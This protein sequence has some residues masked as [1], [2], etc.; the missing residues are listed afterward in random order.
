MKRILFLLTLSTAVLYASASNRYVSPTG[1][2]GNGKS[3]EN[4]KTTIAGA[5]WDV[6]VGDTMFIAEGVYNEA[7]SVQSG[8][9]Y[10]GGYN[11]ETGERNPELYESIIDGTDL[12]SYLI[13]KYDADPT[14]PILMDGL[15]I[16]NADNSAWG[17]AAIFWRGNM[18]LSNCIVRDCKGTSNVGGIYI[19][20]ASSAVKPV[21]KNCIFENCVCTLAEYVGA[22]FNKGGIIENC[23][24]RG[25]SA[26]IAGIRNEGG[27]IVRNCLLHNNHSDYN[28]CLYN[29]SD[30]KI[31]NTTV[32]NNTGTRYAGIRSDGNVMN[33]VFW[34][35]TTSYENINYISSSSGSG[36]NVADKGSSSSC[37]IKLNLNA[38]NNAADGPNFR[39]P[40]GFIGLPKTDVEKDAMRK[41]DFSLTDASNELLDKGT[42]EGAPEKDILG[43][44]RPKGNGIDI[45]AYEY[46]PDAVVIAVTG[47]SIAPSS[48]E[49][50]EGRTGTL[51]AQVEPADANNKR[52]EWSIDNEEIATIKN[53]VVT[54]VKEGETTARVKT[55]D[56]NYTAEATVIITPKPPVKYPKEVLEAEAT[57]KI[58][59]YTVPS[60]IP[61]LVAKQEAKI[62]SASPETTPEMIASIAEKLEVMYTRIEKLQPK[63]QPYNQIATFYGDPA[64]HMGFCWFTNGGIKDGKVQ[65]LAKADATAEDFAS[66]NGVIEVAAQTTDATLHYTP[67]QSSESPKYDICTAAGLPRNTR[68]D[69]VSHKAQ[70]TTLTPGTEYSWRVGFDG[71]WSEIAQ[72]VTKDAN[73][74]AF[75]FLYMTDSHI[76][77]Y[78][79]IGQA[80]Q[81]AE[82]V[83]KNEAN[84]KDVKFC[85][86]PGDFADTG[87][88]TNS[89][90]QWEQWFE[91]S[92]RPAL[93][94]MAFVPTDG[95]HDDSPLLNYDYHFNTDWSF[96]SMAETKP[97]FY[98]ITYSFVYGDVLFLVYSL[99]DWWRAHGSSDKNMV[100]SYITTDLANW[101]KEQIAKYP[102]TKYRV[103]VSHKNIFSGAGHHEDDECPL[104]RELMLPIFKEC[105]IDLA[106]QGHDHCYEVMGPVNPDTRTVIPGS[107]TDTVRVAAEA[108]GRW[109]RSVNKTGLE[110]G[111]FTVDDGTLYFIGAT[112]GRKRYEPYNRATMEENYTTD[113][114]ILFDNKH[115]NVKNLFDLFTSKFGQPGAPSYTRFNVSNAGIEMVTY[116]TDEDGNK[117]E[118]NTIL[119]KRTRPHTLPTGFENGQSAVTPQEGQKFIRDGQVLIQRDGK[120]YNVLGE[121]VQ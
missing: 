52:V 65:I 120:T 29:K 36:Y 71:H 60:F 19:D 79:Y 106:I 28:G 66:S 34:G 86:F 117:E 89:E 31:I 78:E 95:N 88:A 7:I 16:Q 82:A 103:T 42:A 92:M 10:L 30:G 64:T 108:T 45:G 48:I 44:E 13:V 39:N 53:G 21:I 105:E 54:G 90:W 49:I 56:G 83:V 84:D 8:A 114:E 27:G 9:T 85:L 5:I 73:Q 55:E 74:G 72:F 26:G 99:Q 101:F 22:I 87:G 102:N 69:Y 113:P 111:T 37:F 18:T 47:V 81:C 43:V 115:H 38:D 116:K 25:C 46:D 67:I 110:G 20:A 98:G 17:P 32:C 59:D 80:R 12:T 62:D 70:A 104:I 24:I 75:S 112:C 97:Q 35:N 23:V 51:V 40:T 109:E 121:I 58:E 119:V 6:G 63:E 93:N 107:V 91:G 96:A 57:Y 14:D 118:Y 4:A 15:I 76:Q 33:T 3:W 41:A 2:D 77:D 94:K 100:S 61:F 50:I 11:A 1:N 68:F